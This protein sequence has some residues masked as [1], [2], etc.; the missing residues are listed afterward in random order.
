MNNRLHEIA[1]RAWQENADLKTTP[2]QWMALYIKKLCEYLLEECYL[3]LDTDI[4]AEDDFGPDGG[5]GMKRA[6]EILKSHFKS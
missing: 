4:T 2:E 6:V 1:L 5:K 3:V